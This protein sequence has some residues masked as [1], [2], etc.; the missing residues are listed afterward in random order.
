MKIYKNKNVY[1]SFQTTCL[2]SPFNTASLY[3][4]KNLFPRLFLPALLILLTAL[5]P[6][7]RLLSQLQCITCFDQNAPINTGI[8]NLLENGSLDDSDC[9]DFNN[10]ICT[11]SSFYA[12]DV[13]GWTCDGGGVSSYAV[14]FQPTGSF[15]N[16]S[17]AGVYLGNFFCDI[18][19][20]TDDISCLVMDD[21]T[22]S[23]IAE[24]YPQPTTDGYGTDGLHFYQTVTGLTVGTAYTLEFWTG[25]EDFNAFTVEGIFG[26]DIG[27]GTMILTNPP[28]DA[29]EV[30]RRYVIVFVANSTT[31]TIK[32][33]NWGHICS[34]CTE[35]VLDDIMLFEGSNAS[36]SFEANVLGEDGCSLSIETDNLNI[37][38]GNIY[39]WNMGDGTTYTSAE[40]THTYAEPGTYTITLEVESD[41]G[42]ASAQQEVSVNIAQEIEAFF[43]TSQS[44]CNQATIAIDNQSQIP[45]GATISWDMGDGSTFQ[46][47]LETYT[48][49]D[50][51]RYEVTMTIIE[52]ICDLISTYTQEVR[53]RP[54]ASISEILDVPN[55]FTPNGDGKNEVFFP[56]ENANNSVSLNV[57][58]RWGKQVYSTTG[59]Y[60]PWDGR[61]LS[62]ESATDGV[63]FYILT[64]NLVC[65]GKKYDGSKEGFIHLM[66]E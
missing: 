38:D 15:G 27:F 60:K 57:W 26:L 53:V 23:G 51:G 37:Q 63:Y 52:P 32:F 44:D 50:T 66:K 54:S 13:P 58:D 42:S 34:T 41:C 33:T 64:Y 35:V 3:P 36:A 55:V 61:G 12:C 21:C 40:P 49:A 11:T 7:T 20:V 62:D 43:V 48:F 9:E 19:G 24:G 56:I 18:C 45:I 1:A 46:G 4:M 47:P 65:D 28:V 17:G 8:N 16:Y 59:S 6:S 10:Y 29:G 30:G 25:G 22:A 14:H 2:Q 31:H 5:M 39:S